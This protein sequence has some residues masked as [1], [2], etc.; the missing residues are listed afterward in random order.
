MHEELEKHGIPFTSGYAEHSRFGVI[1][2]GP[3]E[4]IALRAGKPHQT[5][6]T[7]VVANQVINGLQSIVSRIVNPL[8]PAVLTIGRIAVDTLYRLG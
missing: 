6:D 1:E 3:G 5:A 2:G 8:D 4:I 7:I